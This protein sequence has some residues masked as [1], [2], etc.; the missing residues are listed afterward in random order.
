M[1]GLQRLPSETS[2]DRRVGASPDVQDAGEHGKQASFVNRGRAVPTHKNDFLAAKARANRYDG[3]IFI[4]G[5]EVKLIYTFTYSF[6][7]REIEGERA[8]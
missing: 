3:Y 7:Q 2:T 6:T 4:G 8:R 5:V 1:Q